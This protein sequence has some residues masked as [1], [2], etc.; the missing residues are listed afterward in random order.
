MHFGVKTS[1]SLKWYTMNK[2]KLSLLGL[3]F[4]LTFSVQSQ[5][6][7]E[8]LGY[9]ATDKLLIITAEDAGLCNA[10]NEAVIQILQRGTVTG[11]SIMVPCA[12]SMEMIDFAKRNTNYTYGL[13]LTLTSEFKNLYTWRP[14]CSA[15]KVPTLLNDKGMMLSEM[16]D[17]Y[18]TANLNQVEAELRAQ[19]EWA[20]KCGLPI[21]YLT[22]HQEVLTYNQ[23]YFDI[24]VKLAAEYSL[25]IRFLNNPNYGN[26]I[27][28]RTKTLAAKGILHPD[29]IIWNELDSIKSNKDV[30]PGME[31]IIKNLKP[32]VT[33]LFV[34]PSILSP[35]IKNLTR[36]YSRKVEEYEW[37]TNPDLLSF[38]KQQGVILISY[39]DL[40]KMQQIQKNSVKAK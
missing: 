10:V 29:A 39:K 8:K 7:A 23:S 27:E 26:D 24:L 32:G 14:I 40:Y 6:L 20:K 15:E 2:I 16:S 1:D 12:W 30:K 13:Q 22:S 36:N 21:N 38:L 35:E 33:E 34:H 25:P 17:L 19:I 18:K 9:K 3:F 11:I 5:T 4:G 37:L 28:A 31:T